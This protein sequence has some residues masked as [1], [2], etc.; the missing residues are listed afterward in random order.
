[1]S[2]KPN[3]WP[4]WLCWV[5]FWFNTTY[6]ASSKMTHFQALYGRPPPVVYHG[7]TYPSNVP[8]VQQLMANKD[9]VLDELKENSSVA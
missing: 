6:N 5:E 8:E 4:Q 2:T 1:M 3:Q 7:E 9:Q